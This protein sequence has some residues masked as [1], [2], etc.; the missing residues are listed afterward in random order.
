MKGLLLWIFNRQRLS[1]VIGLINV[2][3]LLLFLIASRSSDVL[4]PMREA[5]QG[6]GTGDEREPTLNENFEESKSKAQPTKVGRCATRVSIPLL[7]V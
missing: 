7:V 4:V 2:F 6:G 5:E 3:I 1:Q